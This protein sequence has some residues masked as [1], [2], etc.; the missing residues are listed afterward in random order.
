MWPLREKG[1]R[2]RAA[3]QDQVQALASVQVRLPRL[4][5]GLIAELI[6]H[7]RHINDNNPRTSASGFRSTQPW[8]RTEG[9]LQ[10]ID[11]SH[12]IPAIYAD[13]PE[14][15]FEEDATAIPSS[16]IEPESS[17]ALSQLTNKTGNGQYEADH[18]LDIP[19]V[20]AEG[21][22][23]M[24]GNG[25]S[26]S[27]LTTSA[28]D[29]VADAALQTHI[30][31]EIENEIFGSRSWEPCRSVPVQPSD[32]EQLYSSPLSGSNGMSLP[33]ID[34]LNHSA[35]Q[36]M[37]SDP[38]LAF[39]LPVFPLQDPTEAKLFRQWIEHGARRFDMCDAHRHFATVL[40]VR[41]MT[42]KPLVNALFALS[43]KFSADVDE[44]IAAEYYQR[45]LNSLVP[46][47]DQPAALANEDLFAAVVLLRSFEE[48]EGRFVTILDIFRLEHLTDFLIV[49]LYGAYGETHLLG[50]HLFIDASRTDPTANPSLLPDPS[51]LFNSFAF[52]GLRGAAFL[53]ALRQELFIALV[54][55]RP[56]LP[57]FSSLRFNR[58]LDVDGAPADDC[59]WANRIMP[60]AVDV[61]DFCYGENTT[62]N[63][64]SVLRFDE[65]AA[66]AE[67]WFSAKPPTFNPIYIEEPSTT[68]QDDSQG[69]TPKNG[70]SLYP[71][72][73]LLN[74]AA[75][76][77]LQN[78]YLIRI[79][80]SAF[81]PHMPRTGPTRTLFL[82][83]ENAEM[84]Q[85]TR[86]LVGIAR[87]NPMC[88][89]LSVWAAVG[90]ALAGDRF[91][92]RKEQDELIRFLSDTQAS[93]MWDTKS[94]RVHLAEAWGWDVDTVVI[95]RL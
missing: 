79:L 85:H 78:Y 64:Q 1:H 50:S 22:D 6:C 89:P 95:D 38:G 5:D 90:I 14:S 86:M 91:E 43:A 4:L 15:L 29:Q 81:N 39:E 56:V 54:S 20:A 41:A 66:Y 74:D 44:Y 30:S 24:P 84:R 47:L 9:A 92:D 76:T 87:G 36:A 71:S 61:L 65:L 11:E 34:G 23:L 52:N 48:L 32:P 69:A 49:P 67:R 21:S 59:A 83:T 10:F 72:I 35:S 42:C 94:S 45:C 62:N 80:L 25:N 16:A 2:V 46:M 7:F 68:R 17:H 37:N 63:A 3:Q 27:A 33:I 82:R 19:G 53:V 70:G 28:L 12:H 57:A 18:R 31:L 13:S 77:G 58:S 40:P 93:S 8:V 51:S 55:Q 75:A 73:W 88:V 60:F 26:Q